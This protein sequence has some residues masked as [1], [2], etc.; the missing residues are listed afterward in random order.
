MM[1]RKFRCVFVLILISFLSFAQDKDS[2]RNAKIIQN[3][4]SGLN[5]VS[6]RHYSM[7]DKK[8]KI[9]YP[10]KQEMLAEI[11]GRIMD[12]NSFRFMN[13]DNI[14]SL[15]RSKGFF[16]DVELECL[17]IKTKSNAKQNM[18]TLKEF[19]TKY[20]KLPERL[21][22]S[23]D[24]EV[25]NEAPENIL[26]DEKYIMRIEIS[27]LGKVNNDETIY[28]KLLT[29]TTKNVQEANTIYIR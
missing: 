7:D 12:M 23:V 5:I 11:N 25:I 6:S 13:P 2:L 20:Y 19:I 10:R 1:M 26:V 27:S 15:E 4:I 3:Q 21:I 9:L 17:I 18:M 8:P 24:N 28:F 14:E 29:R 16:K 22:F